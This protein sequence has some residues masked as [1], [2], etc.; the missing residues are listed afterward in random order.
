MIWIQV[1]K[2]I[3]DIAP[4][5]TTSCGCTT[6]SAT[7]LISEDGTQYMRIRKLTPLECWRLMRFDDVDFFNAKN[8]GV[9]DTQLYRQAGNSIVVNVLEFIL[10][11]LLIE[12]Y[13]Q[14]CA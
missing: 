5:Q 1:V 9:L 6:S 3:T 2:E 7:I 13:L 14:N 12:D 4:T 10:Q 8:A 11:K